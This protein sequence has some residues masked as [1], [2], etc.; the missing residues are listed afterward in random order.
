MIFATG[1]MHG[2]Y[3]KLK[4]SCKHLKK[5]D[6]LLIAG[7]FGFVWKGDKA[8]EKLLKKIGK[9]KFDICFVD[10]ANENHDL[11]MQYP[12][13][14]Y[15][16]GEAAVISGNLRWLKRGSVFEIEGKKIFAFGGAK[17]DDIES[18]QKCGNWFAAE[19][20]GEDEF[21]YGRENLEKTGWQV[22]YI[23]THQPSAA[24][25]ASMEAGY[26]DCDNLQIYL[27]EIG[28]KTKYTLWVFGRLHRD[29]KITYK[30]TA[31]FKEVV[32][33][34]PPPLKMREKIEK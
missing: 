29:R 13:N 11:L 10:G 14:E 7:D 22:D 15:Q 25:L 33:L 4:T 24:M 30:S 3:K 17:S 31:V 1:D 32:A 21:A 6:T 26:V 28:K 18:K 12:M 5:G 23:L 16:G 27:D 9:S 19:L 2:D 8:E 34:N 20:P